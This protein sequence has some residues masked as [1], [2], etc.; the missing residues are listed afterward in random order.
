MNL[1]RGR[2]HFVLKIYLHPIQN[3]FFMY[4]LNS[5]VFTPQ[6]PAYVLHCMYNYEIK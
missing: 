1:H 4:P 3:T 2:K 6:V 5:F